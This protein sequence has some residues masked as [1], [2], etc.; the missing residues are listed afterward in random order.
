MGH[1]RVLADDSL[2]RVLGQVG[3]RWVR[4]ESPVADAIA[5]L[6]GVKRHEHADGAETYFVSDSDT[7]ISDLVRSGLPF[8]ELAVRGATL[9]EAFL[10]LTESSKPLSKEAV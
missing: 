8:H 10:L 5:D 3:L 6:P 2:K 9:E 1:G 4:L 7:F